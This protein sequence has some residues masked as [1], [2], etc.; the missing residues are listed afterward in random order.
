MQII[1]KSFSLKSYLTIK[2]HKRRF[3]KSFAFAHI[4]QAVIIKEFFF[5]FIN[6]TQMNYDN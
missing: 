2:E 4:L 6:H 3:F 5:K 1:K